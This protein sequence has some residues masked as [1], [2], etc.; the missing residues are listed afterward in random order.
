MIAMEA[1]KKN[2]GNAE[3]ATG[4]ALGTLAAGGAAAPA[5]V[6]CSSGGCVVAIAVASAAAA[7]APVFAAGAVALVGIGAYRKLKK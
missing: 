4:S 2:A 1:K 5:L 7:A 6:A 3:L